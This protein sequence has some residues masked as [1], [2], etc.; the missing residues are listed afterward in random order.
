MDESA[1]FIPTD[2]RKNQRLHLANVG[3]GNGADMDLSRLPRCVLLI[4]LSIST[5]LF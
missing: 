3:E 2:Y 5:I 4:A 1:E